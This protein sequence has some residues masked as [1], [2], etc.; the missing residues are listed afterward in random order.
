MLADLQER[1]PVWVG[2][3]QGF[4]NNPVLAGPGGG[5]EGV[6]PLCWVQGMDFPSLRAVLRAHT[7]VNLE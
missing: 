5:G 6:E 4:K 2:R 7:E 3:G 1:L